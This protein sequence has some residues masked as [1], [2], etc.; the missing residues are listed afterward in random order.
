[1]SGDQYYPQ[2]HLYCT[3]AESG[4][5]YEGRSYF[6]LG[7]EH[8]MELNLE[9]RVEPEMLIQLGEQEN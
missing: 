5:P 8:E 2:P 1:M 9:D 6:L 3:F 4:E 7:N